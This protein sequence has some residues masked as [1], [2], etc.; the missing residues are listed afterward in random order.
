MNRVVDPC[1]APYITEPGQLG[2]STSL[3]S[4][5]LGQW[6]RNSSGAA[7]GISLAL[8]S[9]GFE[10]WLLLVA[11]AFGIGHRIYS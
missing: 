5:R 9:S 7:C 4:N 11:E 10:A 6:R 8:V 2:I 3:C 1:A